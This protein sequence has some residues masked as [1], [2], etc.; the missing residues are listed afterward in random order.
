V[1]L[2][3]NPETNERP[4]TFCGKDK[5]P[6][7]FHART[8]GLVPKRKCA[9]IVFAMNLDLEGRLFGVLLGL[10]V[11]TIVAWLTGRWRLS[12][13]KRRLLAGDAGDTLVIEFQMVE[14]LAEGGY[15]LRRRYLGM[16]PVANVIQNPHLLMEFRKRAEEAGRSGWFISMEGA[17][18]T[19]LL[20]CLAGFVGD[21]LGNSP[22]DHDLYVMVPC[23]DP[24]QLSHYK[25]LSVILISKKD[26]EMFLSW[27]TVE[28]IQTERSTD[29]VRLLTLMELANRWQK[30]QKLIS[31]HR[32]EGKSTRH[33][34]T[35][36]LLDL[37]IN[38]RSAGIPTRPVPWGRYLQELSARGLPLTPETLRMKMTGGIDHVET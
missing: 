32:V 24:H 2:E 8:N 31:E 22:L 27:Q 5:V 16:S 11:G 29:A 36:F 38:R 6:Q 17:K 10:T 34:E 23:R 13:A 25:S 18:G 1:I 3:E 28:R 15:C 12:R 33:L 26:L 14:Q 4:S 7:R 20:E 37:G 9:M 30:E 21:R 19:Y 35:M